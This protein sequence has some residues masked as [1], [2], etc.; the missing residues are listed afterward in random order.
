MQVSHG[1]LY[2]TTKAISFLARFDKTIIR[3]IQRAAG[4]LEG[5]VKR[6]LPTA[7]L[8]HHAMCTLQRVQV[9]PLNKVLP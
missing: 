8:R 9:T 4:Q 3:T 5:D 1:G 2:G 6:L 7:L